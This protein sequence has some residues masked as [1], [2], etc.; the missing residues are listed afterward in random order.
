[1]GEAKNIYFTCL[2]SSADFI[3]ATFSLVFLLLSVALA[4]ADES[5]QNLDRLFD[6][7]NR[8]SVESDVTVS[9]SHLGEKAKPC[10]EKY[11]QL[12]SA[13]A[14]ALKC[15]KICRPKLSRSSSCLPSMTA[16]IPT[17]LNFTTSCSRTERIPTVV[18]FVALFT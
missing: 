8:P 17:W 13:S 2:K 18:R 11:C 4:S 16:S 1:M 15:R 14:P 9:L 3:M 12:P 10:S 7:P 6:S 5:V